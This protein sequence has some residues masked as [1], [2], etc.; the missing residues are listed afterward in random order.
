LVSP[1]PLS[2]ASFQ[3]PYDLLELYGLF[4][5]TIPS[6]PNSL[7]CLVYSSIHDSIKTNNSNFTSNQ[8]PDACQVSLLKAACSNS[9][10][11]KLSQMINKNAIIAEYTKSCHQK[12]TLSKV[13]TIKKDEPTTKPT[14]YLT[15]SQLAR[16]CSMK[17]SLNH[18]YMVLDVVLDNVIVKL[19]KPSESFL[20]D[21]DVANLSE[22][23]CL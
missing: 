20:T 1:P 22:V 21:E 18:Q 17:P 16:G 12:R 19:L 10:A 13:T 11:L 2:F 9:S 5:I 15:I 8:V 14:K 7:S 3:P 4:C 6:K 23:N